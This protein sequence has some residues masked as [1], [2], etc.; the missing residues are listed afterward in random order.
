M[1][2]PHGAVGW[3]DVCGCG[4][5]WPRGYKTFFKLNSTDHGIYH[6]HFNYW[7]FTFISMINRTSEKLK[8]RNFFVCGYFSFY[9]QLKFR[10]QLS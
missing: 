8:A 4:I 1:A 10:A 7:H 3:S 2:L 9:E 6:A 5:S